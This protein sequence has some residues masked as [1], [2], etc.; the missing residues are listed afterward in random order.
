MSHPYEPVI[1]GSFLLVEDQALRDKVLEVASNF[2]MRD[3]FKHPDGSWGSIRISYDELKDA[4]AYMAR[5]P[6]S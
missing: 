5:T 1:R 4:L 2:H 6:G 3:G